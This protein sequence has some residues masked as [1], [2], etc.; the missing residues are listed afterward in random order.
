MN[1]FVFRLQDLD[2]TKSELVGAKAANLAEL[3][4]MKGIRV[5]AGAVI[6][7]EY[8]LPAVVGVDKRYQTDPGRSENPGE[9]NGGLCGNTIKWKIQSFLW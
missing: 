6:A 1:S 3:I 7:R 5:P 8:G 2:K 9:R 4:G